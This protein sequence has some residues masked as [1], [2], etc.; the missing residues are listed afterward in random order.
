MARMGPATKVKRSTVP[1][2]WRLPRKTF[3]FSIR[4]SS[5]PHPIDR[6]YPLLVLLRDVLQVVKTARESDAVLREGKVLVDGVPRA[7]GN[8]PA[9]L[10]DVVE[11]PS[12]GKVYR[13]LPHRRYS[14]YP[15]SVKESEKSLKLCLVKTKQTV[16]KG[17]IQLGL[18]DGK[19]VLLD[20]G[21][22]IKRGDACLLDLSTGKITGSF[23]LEK[24]SQA[25]AI[26]G[27]KA[28][29]IG[30]VEEIKAGTATRP[31]MA[32]LSIEGS[33]TELPVHLVMPLGKE[34]LPLTVTSEE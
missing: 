14:L 13:L 6:S 4:T 23:R 10:M 31:A 25:L 32:T 1:G 30:T 21:S 2:F 26:R 34:R 33:T 9:G 19:S 15:V 7:R 3:E 5:G 12:I 11:I 16:A 20:D 8:F 29:L 17:K 22:T 27:E 24:G 18:H 28:G